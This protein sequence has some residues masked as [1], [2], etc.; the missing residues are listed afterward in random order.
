MK[1]VIGFIT[2][3]FISGFLSAQTVIPDAAAIDN[4]AELKVHSTNRGVVIPALSENQIF[5]IG[6]A[7]TG[8]WIY[9]TT[10]NNFVSYD[11]SSWNDMAKTRTLAADPAG[12]YRGEYYFNTTDNTLNYW[13]G[14]AWV[15][16]GLTGATIP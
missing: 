3:L 11:G 7:A 2:V 13:N 9:N 6:N 5:S 1:Q 8:L 10:K 4:K 15:K 16:I 14:S 12:T